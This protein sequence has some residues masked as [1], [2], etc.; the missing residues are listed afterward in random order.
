M[1]NLQ[2]I[3]IISYVRVVAA[4]LWLDVTVFYLCVC[5]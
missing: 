1:Y 2:V 3:V 5:H 4:R